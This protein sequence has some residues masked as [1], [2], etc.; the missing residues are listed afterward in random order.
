[1][2]QAARNVGQGRQTL[3]LLSRNRIGQTRRLLDTRVGQLNALGPL[4]VLKR[5]YTLALSPD[6]K[7]LHSVRQLKPE[8]MLHLRFHDGT[9]DAEV[10]ETHTHG[11]PTT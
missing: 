10:R 3:Q 7:V 4:G 9:A 8:D 11:A 2:Q 1:M 5:G 6:G